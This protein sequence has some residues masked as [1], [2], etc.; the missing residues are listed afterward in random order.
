MQRVGR[1]RQRKTGSSR[2]RRC[3][4]I[5]RPGTA[6]A[7][8]P[9]VARGPRAW[10]MRR[11][12]RQG[13]ARRSGKQDGRNLA[14][15]SADWDEDACIAC[16]WRRRCTA[17]LPR[18]AATSSCCARLRA[19]LEE[20]VGAMRSDAG[21]EA[22]PLQSRDS[23]P[24]VDAVAVSTDPRHQ[25][26][27]RQGRRARPGHPASERPQAW[28]RHGNLI[29]FAEACKALDEGDCRCSACYTEMPSA[30]R[31][32]LLVP[33]RD[34]RRQS[35]C[36]DALHG[37]IFGCFPSMAMPLFRLPLLTCAGH[38]PWRGAGDPDLRRSRRRCAEGTC[39]PFAGSD[40]GLP[41]AAGDG[42]E[43]TRSRKSRRKSG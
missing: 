5:G 36:A 34:A 43:K 6:T 10:R 29:V 42:F 9:A 11:R 15:G 41:S 7:A 27:L 24:A 39:S 22:D 28:R 17:I 40:Y 23:Y 33:S 1:V 18:R 37:E 14:Q 4:A 35:A 31:D 20:S 12:S 13:I 3:A 16:F 8:E 2:R 26:R 25:S 19:R 38:A 30:V 21:I 32:L